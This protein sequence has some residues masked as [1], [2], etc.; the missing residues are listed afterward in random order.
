[1]IHHDGIFVAIACF[2][3]FLSGYLKRQGNDN[4][5]ILLNVIGVCFCLLY[6]HPV[7]SLPLYCYVY[8]LS[9]GSKKDASNNNRSP[10]RKGPVGGF[11]KPTISNMIGSRRK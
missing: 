1:M 6:R 10:R 11:G 7:I 4:V 5:S 2:I 9:K 8:W 3:A